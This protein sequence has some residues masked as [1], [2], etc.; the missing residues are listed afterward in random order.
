MRIPPLIAAPAAL[1]L[2]VLI[3]GSPAGPFAVSAAAA[4]APP[5]IPTA[6]RGS[7]PD[8]VGPLFRHGVNHPH[9]CTASVLRSPERDLLLTAAHCVSGT[10]S[11]ITFAPGY[12]DGATPFGVWAVTAAYVDPSWIAAQDPQHDYAILRVAHQFIDGRSIGVEDVVGGNR[13]GYAPRDGQQV[14]IPAYPAGINDEPIDCTNRTYRTGDYPSFDCDGYVG[15]TSGSPWLVAGRSD[16]SG[17]NT[18]DRP[19]GGPGNTGDRPD[20]DGLVVGVIGG[21]HQGG[22]VEYTSYSSAFGPDSRRLWR[23]AVSG[24]AG[25]TVPVAGSDG[26]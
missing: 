23:R 6:T 3:A 24:L 1:L 22:C 15:G 25:D 26:C 16:E 7:A 18:G 11:S 20:R 10:G 2:A 13:L 12:R 8:N 9:S 17:G 14:S 5:G 19:D 4:S 21:L